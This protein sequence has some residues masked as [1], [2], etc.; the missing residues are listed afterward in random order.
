LTNWRA[1]GIGGHKITAFM[2]T[3][4]D[5]EIAK[6][7]I[8]LYGGLYIGLRLPLTAQDD[9][10]WITG[11]GPRYKVN[12][13]GGHCV[14]L[15]GYDEEWLT[16]VTFGDLQKL[17]WEFFLKYWDEVYVVYSEDDWC[18]SLKSPVGLDRTALLADVKIVTG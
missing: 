14:A 3:F 6:E 16:C 9:G 5:R 2:E 12:S 18:P 11:E 17:S 15:V 8:Y 1:E 10:P 13:W 7:A 4:A